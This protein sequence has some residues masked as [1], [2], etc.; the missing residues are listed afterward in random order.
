MEEDWQEGAA[1]HEQ[2]VMQHDP[3]FRAMMEGEERGQLFDYFQN[4]NTVQLSGNLVDNS[5]HH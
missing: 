2:D 1:R 3:N 4:P 5:R